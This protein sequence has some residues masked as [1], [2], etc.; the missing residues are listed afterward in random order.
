MNLDGNVLG[1][2]WV[3]SMA[4]WNQIPKEEQKDQIFKQT[5]LER[6]LK[7]TYMQLIFTKYAF[8]PEQLKEI[9]LEAY[10]ENWPLPKMLKTMEDVRRTFRDNPLPPLPQQSA[11][12]PKEKV[13]I[14]T[15]PKTAAPPEQQLPKDVLEGELLAHF[16]LDGTL[17]DMSGN[18][19]VLVNHGAEPAQDKNGVPEGAMQFKKG[20]WVEV[21][22]SGGMNPKG[23]FTASMWICPSVYTGSPPQISLAKL[24]AGG[25][26][27]WVL[28]FYQNGRPWGWGN[29][30]RLHGKNPLPLN[31]WHHLCLVWDGANIYLYANGETV[32]SAKCTAISSGANISSGSA[33]D[34][35]EPCSSKIDDI[36]LWNKALEPDAVRYL[37]ENGHQSPNI[38]VP[39]YS[40]LKKESVIEDLVAKVTQD[41]LVEVPMTERDAGIVLRKVYNDIL[42]MDEVVKSARQ[43]HITIKLFSDEDS[44]GKGQFAAVLVG[45]KNHKK[46]PRIIINRMFFQ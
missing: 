30:A 21:K 46:P 24:R 15:P 3:N 39:K 28:G 43:A 40:I 37:Y 6:E 7:E 5:D 26:A 19:L 33:A 11:I 45:S 35:G 17:T 36:L 2:G 10:E 4:L 31:K 13:I 34:G 1:H 18:D 27:G 42:E 8:T 22:N 14:S 44:V 32:A 38:E 20:G 29:G 9:S 41:I 16:P 25:S 12:P 23:A